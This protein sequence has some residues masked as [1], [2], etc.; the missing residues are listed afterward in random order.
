MNALQI[1]IDMF[2]VFCAIAKTLASFAFLS[3]RKL[4]QL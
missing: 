4:I 2:L 1:Y 3:L